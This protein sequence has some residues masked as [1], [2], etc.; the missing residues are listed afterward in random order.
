MAVSSPAKVES[1]KTVWTKYMK[2][3]PVDGVGDVAGIDTHGFWLWSGALGAQVDQAADA[4][5]GAG[6][7]GRSTRGGVGAGGNCHLRP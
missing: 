5:G 3:I 7:D 6:G 2:S 1:A 4:L